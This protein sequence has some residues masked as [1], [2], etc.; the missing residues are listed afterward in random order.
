MIYKF[1]L[2]YFHINFRGSPCKISTYLFQPGVNSSPVSINYVNKKEY[3]IPK[4]PS[5][6]NKFLLSINIK[7]FITSPQF[8]IC[9]NEKLCSKTK[10]W[11]GDGRIYFQILYL[12]IPL[13]REGAKPSLWFTAIWHIILNKKREKYCWQGPGVKPTHSSL[14]K[15]PK[16]GLY[17][18][19]QVY[20]LNLNHLNVSKNDIQELVLH[21]AP[22]T[23]TT[24]LSVSSSKTASKET[25]YSVLGNK[26]STT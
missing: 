1:Y 2:F 8:N 4:I 9:L 7:I 16:N 18:K 20:T 14:L 23:A 13:L 5:I 11:N 10:S 6:F 25:S 26:P 12:L 19:Y 22:R 17:F 15:Q 3:G 21:V 24:S